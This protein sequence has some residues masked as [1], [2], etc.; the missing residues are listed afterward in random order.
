MCKWWGSLKWNS[1]DKRLQWY[2]WWSWNI[3]A[4]EWEAPELEF[5][6]SC[7]TSGP[8]CWEACGTGTS[9]VSCGKGTPSDDIA[10]NGNGC[11]SAGLV[12][13][14]TYI[15][16]TS[17]RFDIFAGVDRHR[18][19]LQLQL[20]QQPSYRPVSHSAVKHY[21]GFE[22]DTLPLWGGWYCL[23]ESTHQCYGSGLVLYIHWWTYCG[24]DSA[25]P[26]WDE[27]RTAVEGGEVLPTRPN[28][29]T[30]WAIRS[31]I[32]ESL[33]TT[34]NEMRLTFLRLWRI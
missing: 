14:G 27:K 17:G 34:R 8:A 19:G 10:C 11:C 22:P 29:G 15:C 31:R 30:W 7:K 4:S 24:R 6:S 20:T 2:R 12:R 25:S 21:S 18:S 3:S 9:Q 1:A 16:S 23:G 33:S 28:H 13:V 32:K 5:P 26:P